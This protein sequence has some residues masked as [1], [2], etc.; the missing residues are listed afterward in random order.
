M[1]EVSDLTNDECFEIVAH[2]VSVLWPAG[3]PDAEWDA[4]T[5]M[6]IVSKL[7]DYDLVPDEKEER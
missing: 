6:A 7:N 5:L 3:V 2:L 4:D 1:R